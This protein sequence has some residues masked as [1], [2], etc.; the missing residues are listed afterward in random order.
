MKHISELLVQRQRS[1]FERR[2]EKGSSEWS[3]F[4]AVKGDTISMFDVAKPQQ[5]TIAP[6]RGRVE[7]SRRPS[8]YP[9]PAH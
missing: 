5:R 6:Q 1:L 7:I 4:N 8:F 2:S 9:H 3:A